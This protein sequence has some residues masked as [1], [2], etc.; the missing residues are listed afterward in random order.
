[1]ARVSNVVTPTLLTRRRKNLSG[2]LPNDSVVSEA[3]E[4]RS[5]SMTRD[6]IKRS[7]MSEGFRPPLAYSASGF[8]QSSALLLTNGVFMPFRGDP[9]EFSLNGTSVRGDGAGGLLSPESRK[10]LISSADETRAI[11]NMLRAVGDQKWAAGETFVEMQKSIDMIGDSAKVLARG[12]FAASRR[13][14]RGVAKALGVTPVKVKSGASESSGWL[15]YHFGWAPVV[16]D[17]ANSA[18]YLSGAFDGGE[19][20][21][22][23]ARTKLREVSVSTTKS[24]SW[25]TLNDGYGSIDCE[26]STKTE[27]VDEYKASVYYELQTSYL[28]GLAQYGLVGLSTPWAVLPSSYLIDWVIP[29]GDFL[30][31]WDATIG[32]SYKGGSYTRFKKAK[33]TRTAISVTY[34]RKPAGDI[35][36][37]PVESFD[38]RRT[39]WASS[40]LPFPA[41]IKNPFDVFKAV[42]SVA[43][44]RQLKPQ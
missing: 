16:Q 38:M 2:G 26:H 10:T 25:W 44:L 34:Q 1:M 3:Y 28:R 12:L 6:D 32:L 15:S 27:F 9:I 29:I 33:S 42:T 14:W 11:V 13:D 23:M 31:A 18:L 4:Y 20:P 24:K 30:A 36:W 22:I 7:A 35:H 8:N 41:Y 17:I 19:P 37:L 43:L 39:V 21:I 5:E 40:P